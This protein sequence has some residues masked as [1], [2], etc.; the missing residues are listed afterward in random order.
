[1]SLPVPMAIMRDTTAMIETTG[2][3]T[4]ADLPAPPRSNFDMAKTSAAR[5]L[6]IQFNNLTNKWNAM[7]DSAIKTLV[8]E[9]PP[10]REMMD[11]IH[12]LD[13]VL[14]RLRLWAG[15]LAAYA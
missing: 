5:P 8:A 11:S 6:A 10:S 7:L 4:T 14:F 12:R 1:M 15:D 3:Q 2:R 9:G 13:D